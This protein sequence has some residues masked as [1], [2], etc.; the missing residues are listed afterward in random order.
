[1]PEQVPNTLN[2]I[3]KLTDMLPQLSE[4][5]AEAARYQIEQLKNENP[6]LSGKD[7]N[8]GS[9]LECWE[10]RDTSRVKILK[11]RLDQEKNLL[12]GY[13][14]ILQEN[15]TDVL[16]ERVQKSQRVIYFI[17]REIAMIKR[18][19]SDACLKDKSYNP[20]MIFDSTSMEPEKIV[21]HNGKAHLSI[22][23]IFSKNPLHKNMSI[24]IYTDDTFIGKV[25]AGEIEDSKSISIEFK[26]V[27]R[28]EFMLKTENDVV[29][30]LVYFPIENL[31]DAEDVGSK[32]FYYTI[33][34]KSMLSISFGNCK[35][36]ECGIQ[37]NGT[38]IITKRSS[39]HLLRKLEDISLYRCGVCGHNES[40]DRASQ[41]YR[42]DWC[43][44]TCHAHC[45]NLIFFEC[46]EFKKKQEAESDKKALEK[47]VEEMKK[48]RL[49]IIIAAIDIREKPNDYDELA[50][51]MQKPSKEIIKKGHSDSEKDSSDSDDKAQKPVKRYSV[52]HNLVK[53]KMLGITWCCHCGERIGMLTVALECSVCQNAY[54]TECRGMIFKS[55]GITKELL[56]G[57]V[58]YV[59]KKKKKDKSEISLSE[60]KFLYLIC[61]EGNGKVYLCS[62]RDKTVAL[63]AI[64]KKDIVESNSEELVDTQRICLEIAK[65]SGNP[66]IVKM[67]GCFQTTTHIF[68]ILEF[69]EGGDLY[70]H[71][72]SR[73]ITPPEIKM[74]LAGLTI[75]LEWLHE[76]NIIYRDLRLENVMFAKNGYVKLTNL[77]LCSIGAPNG[78]AHTLCGSF[79]NVAPEV[80]DEHY[81][82]AADWWSFGVL[83]YQLVL[84]TSPFIAGSIKQTKEA[85]QNDPPANLELIEEPMRSLIVGLLEKSADSRIGTKSI[86]EIKN[87]P[88]FSD[89]DWDKMKKQ[90][91]PVVWKPSTE[92]PCMNF[93]S[94]Q[95]KNSP[96]LSPAEEIDNSHNAYFQ[97]F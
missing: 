68:F 4:T 67:E 31:V 65:S 26:D 46:F 75:A 15:T 49:N 34:E 20:S 70:Y 47:E 83:A 9:V 37:R 29:A 85:I 72:H 12:E 6:F 86:W 56:E 23:G 16:L 76:E 22:I 77:G 61:P 25:E 19:L 45:M 79:P 11:Q 2:I 13:K 14:V 62:W 92:K 43:K 96:S 69:V 89:I 80:I 39:G 91:L 40:K 41:F 38:S 24:N 5:E 74:I 82:K 63:K 28:I 64:K 94:A 78:V 51:R 71:L 33:A 59:P 95:I 32:S 48:E 90:E 8:P 52:E 10:A 57:L 27:Y 36:E 50:N 1:M 93:E 42:C 17:E 44:F 7:K 97:N 30:G 88:Y 84:K 60:F 55:C 21:K 87:H 73:E 53:Q 81:T 66:F 58:A 35:L 18:F 54:H 3:K